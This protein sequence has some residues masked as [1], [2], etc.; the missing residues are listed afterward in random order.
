MA[1]RQRR[2]REAYSIASHTATR[3]ATRGK[4]NNDKKTYDHEL[5]PGDRVLVRARLSAKDLE[6]SDPTGQGAHCT[7]EKDS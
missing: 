3:E 1:N 5:Q 7:P 2:M 4:V 6:N